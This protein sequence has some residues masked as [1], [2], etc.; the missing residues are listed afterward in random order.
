MRG[1]VGKL[2]LGLAL[3]GAAA[4]FL[5][6]ATLSQV[7]AECEACVRHGAVEHCAAAAAAT[8]A[9]AERSAIATACA[10]VVSGVTATLQCQAQ[11]PASLACR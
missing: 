6:R 9:E 8:R 3:A 5:Y 11:P 7:G 10:A 4:A 2:A 1:R